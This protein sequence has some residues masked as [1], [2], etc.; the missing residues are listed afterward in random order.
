MEVIAS[1]ISVFLA[2]VIELWLGI[3]LGLFLDLNPVLIAITAAAGSILSAF[4]FAILGEGIR[5]WFIK[6]RYNGK[7]PKEGKIYDIWNKYGI[8]G[9]G[10]LSPLLFGAPLGTALGIGLGAPKDRLLLWMTIGIVIWSAF[11]TAAG[12]FGLMSFQS[13]M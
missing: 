13:I 2:S 12:F 11:L 9:L 8:V 7:S 3:P 5:K 1:V 4:L 10:L 6:W